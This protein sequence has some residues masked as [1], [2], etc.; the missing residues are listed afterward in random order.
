MDPLL[1]AS[2]SQNQRAAEK[3]LART[4]LLTEAADGEAE[5]ARRLIKSQQSPK[6]NTP[7]S[8]HNK[9]GGP[10][11]KSQAYVARVQQRQ[12]DTQD[13]SRQFFDDLLNNIL[14]NK[15]SAD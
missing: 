9:Y 3:A 15:S 14:A 2:L 11:P 1:A 10:A 7:G 4:D 6:P 12:A 13:R 5:F 8:K